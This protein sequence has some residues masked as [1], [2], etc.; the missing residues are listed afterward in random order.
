MGGVGG[1]GVRVEDEGAKERL[2]GC[3]E[4][5]EMAFKTEPVSADDD[6]DEAAEGGVGLGS[7]GD[8]GVGDGLG[9]E[10]RYGG[11]G[12]F[13]VPLAHRVPLLIEEVLEHLRC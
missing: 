12:E 3:D 8:D 2:Q 5:V 11:E 4:D 9:G 13:D 7:G 6:L 10:N 1:G